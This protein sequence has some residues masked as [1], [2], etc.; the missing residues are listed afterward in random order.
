MEYTTV[1]LVQRI[2]IQARPYWLCI[3]GILLLGLL[4]APIALIKP[5]AIKLLIDSAFGSHP[6]PGFIRMLFPENFVFS[7]SAVV[8]VSATL[9]IIV[10]LIENLHSFVSGLLETYTG[11]KLV[12]NFRMLL[13]NHIQRISLAYHDKKGTADSLYRLQWDTTAIRSLLLGSLPSLV[14]SLITLVSMIIVMFS[15]H[16]HFA[17]IT[18]CII[19]PLFILTR[20]SR[21]RIKRGWKKIK[22]DE[23]FAMA[24]LHEVMGSLRVVKAFGQ[25]DKEEKRFADQ[26]DKAIKEQLEMARFGSFYN[27]M[28][29]LLFALGTALF[30]Y[31]GARYVQTGQMTLGELTLVLAYLG[32]VFGPLQSIAKNI[33]HLQSSILS[34][35]RVFELLD[36]EKEVIENTN[37]LPLPKVKGAFEFQNVEFSY[38]GNKPVLQNVSFQIQAGERVGIIGSTGAGKTTL[39]S[40]LIRFY[41]PSSGRILLDGT[42]IKSFRL[43]DYRSQFG[44]VLQEPVLFSTTIAENIRYGRPDVS[45]KEIIEAAKAANAHDF[46]ISNPD[47]YDAMVGERGMQ[48]SGGER[49]RI[50]LA[51]AFIKN[52]PVLIL[53]EPTSSVDIK[54]EALILDAMERLMEGRTTFM[55]THRLDTLGYCD[56]ILHL[57]EGKIADLVR[58]NDPDFLVKKKAAFLN[59]I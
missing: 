37:P 50:S 14:S 42:D 21:K 15:I 24:V 43:S 35:E 59:R 19:P 36:Q 4:S 8:F 32:Q 51:R 18:F 44:I 26:A 47:G 41:D 38:D 56:L 28:V 10:T 48:L 45:Q 17:L 20:F 39:I 52:A 5:L 12:L 2:M 49:Q 6:V 55:I 23:S 16:R 53:D 7:F 1:H 54:T 57:E 33:N 34:I 46:I 13:F 29:G 11:E 27:F 40:L 30:I 22:K 31:F 58:K 25:E 9:V 3:A